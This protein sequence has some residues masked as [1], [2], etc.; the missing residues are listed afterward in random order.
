ML[1]HDLCYFSMT[2][3]WNLIHQLNIVSSIEKNHH[4]NLQ[5]I[6]NFPPDGD[7][8]FNVNPTRGSNLPH[9]T[10]LIALLALFTSD[11]ILFFF[12]YRYS[13]LLLNLITLIFYL[14]F[15]NIMN[16]SETIMTFPSSFTKPTGKFS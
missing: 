15:T 12:H 11:T 5:T 4:S 7:P 3:I 10:K 9:L 6:K 14:V 2:S 1:N 16:E 8:T 13:I